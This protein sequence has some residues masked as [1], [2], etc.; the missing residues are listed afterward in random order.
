MEIITSLDNDYIKNINKLHDKKYRDANNLFLV[1]SEHLIDAAYDASMLKEIIAL[2]SYTTSKNVKITYVSEA[3]MKKLS[4]MVSISKCLG[5]VRKFEP[6]HYGKRLLLLDDIQDP[7]NL[8]TIIRSAVAF[9]IDTIIL[10]LGCVDLYNDKVIRSSEGMLF[11]ID[12]IRTDLISLVKELKENEYA[13]YAT[14]V[15]NGKHL[16]DIDLNDKYGIII[17]NEGNGVN[18]KLLNIADDNIYIPINKKCESLNAAVA[19]SIIM[20]EISKVDY[21]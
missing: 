4:N 17:G 16:N 9:N 3:V 10:G 6:N 14:S 12:I 7:G 15:V 8:G 13:I 2:P 1:E 19:A 5:V 20:Y 18:D 11:N 21:E